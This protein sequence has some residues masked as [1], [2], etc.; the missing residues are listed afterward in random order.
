MFCCADVKIGSAAAA[1][2]LARAVGVNFM[3]VCCYRVI[4]SRMIVHCVR[5]LEGIVDVVSS[6]EHQ[7]YLN[8]ESC[9]RDVRT[10][11]LITANRCKLIA[12][13]SCEKFTGV[14]IYILLLA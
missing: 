14:T 11:E 5:S 4:N 8:I 3:V 1:T 2:A 12:A 13:V 6:A 9:V 7:T 10:G